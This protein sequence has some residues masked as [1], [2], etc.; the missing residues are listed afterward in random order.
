MKNNK[1]LNFKQ[2][3]KA[4][5]LAAGVGSRINEI[6]KKIPKTMIKINKKYIFE[7]ILENLHKASEATTK[8]ALSNLQQAALEN[9]NVFEHLMEAVKFCSLGQITDALFAVGGQYRRSM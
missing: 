6:T 9:E 1:L 5:V 2:N 7:Y 4:V 8:T 3:Y